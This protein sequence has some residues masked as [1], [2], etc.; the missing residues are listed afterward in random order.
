M[1]IPIPIS[2]LLFLLL[3]LACAAQ[4]A[5]EAR[6]IVKYKADPMKRALAL[7]PDRRASL[8]ARSGLA[9]RGGRMIDARSESL[10]ADGL[11]SEEL[12]ARLAQDPDVEYAV[13]DRLRKIRALPNDPMF[14]GQWHLQDT[15]IAAIRAS[16]AWDIH[17]GSSDV[18]IAVIDTGVR[19]DHPD[20]AA[21]LLPGHDF[22]ADAAN[23]GD[24]DGWDGD[25]GDP[26]DYL[27]IS[28]LSDPRL[29]AL[30]GA[31]TVQ[32][33]SWHGTRIAGVLAAGNN[34]EGV[35]GVSWGVRILPARVLGKCGGYDSDIIAA[36]RW[37]G[38]LSVPGVADAP[39]PARIL[40]LSLGGDGACSA[41]YQSAINELT[42]RGVLVTVAAGNATGPVES[43]ANCSGVLAVG[44]VRHVGAK[45]GYSSFGPEVGISA[46]AGNCVNSNGP[47]L[48]SIQ[49][50]WNDGATDPGANTYTDAIHYNVGTSFAAPQVA[51][52]AALMLSVNPALQ[53]AEIIRRIQSTARPFPHDETLPTCP[54]TVANGDSIGQCN[55]TTS[56]CGAGLLDAA[57]AVAAALV[58]IVALD[59]LVPGPIRLDS[60]GSQAISG[61]SIASRR[62]TLVSGP[63]G[64]SL[65]STTAVIATLQ[66][67]KAGTYVVNLSVTDNT[68]ASVS[69][70]SALVVSAPSSGGGGALGWPGLAL[71]G[72]LALAAKRRG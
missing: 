24:G 7:A 15:E 35:A 70:S 31:M 4:A 67:A 43:P 62:W 5:P 9:L 17:T 48:F 61:R 1:P 60:S 65:S 22:V 49:T 11:S 58:S 6:V 32:N 29:R 10:R 45:V 42:A 27:S 37:S 34:G 72:L 54:E 55:C 51:G 25:A 28:D 26:G 3:F 19:F 69:Y 36:M 23:A 52:V 47:C 50:T 46:P 12:A 56:T 63:E 18:V 44:G 57:N 40:N 30:C 14:S 21:K 16:A 38:G 20:L 66:A 13:P 39:T 59:P 71:L 68:G 2:I 64:G 53:P 41:A 33:S 8:A